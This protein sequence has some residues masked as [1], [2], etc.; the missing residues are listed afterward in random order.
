MVRG[1]DATNKTQS[2]GRIS[3]LNKFQTRAQA[4]S[5]ATRAIHE[6]DKRVAAAQRELRSRED[7]QA[8]ARLARHS[9]YDPKGSLLSDGEAAALADR[10]RREAKAAK[11]ARFLAEAE[12]AA[13]LLESDCDGGGGAN[14]DG[15]AS[16]AATDGSEAATPP[17]PLHAVRCAAPLPE[18]LTVIVTTSPLPR[19]PCSRLLDEIVRSVHRH[20]AGAASCRRSSR[21][22]WRRRRER[23]WLRCSALRAASPWE[24]AA[25]RGGR[26]R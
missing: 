11:A 18:L 12:R 22:P 13:A 15:A 2:G 4:I 10:R 7:A 25:P 6:R 24:Q 5:N 19:H 3:R 1:V 14:G 9:G 8:A 23:V 20:C 16:D 21:V 26:L 17:A